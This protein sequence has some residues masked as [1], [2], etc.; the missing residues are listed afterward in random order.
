M[1][2]IDDSCFDLK[3][4]RLF[5]FELVLKLLLKVEVCSLVCHNSARNEL[6]HS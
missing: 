6:F 4:K 5:I 1:T 3:R 2:V